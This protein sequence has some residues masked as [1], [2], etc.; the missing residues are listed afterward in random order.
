MSL[1]WSL[2]GK[3]G[4]LLARSLSASGLGWGVVG[5]QGAGAGEAMAEGGWVGETGGGARC[6]EGP[7]RLRL[8]WLHG[9]WALDHV[10]ERTAAVRGQEWTWR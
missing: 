4:A 2:P 7:G 8:G 1:D 6:P 5:A 3:G 9:P 10:R